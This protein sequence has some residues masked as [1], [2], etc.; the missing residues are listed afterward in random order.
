M[1][2]QMLRHV[3]GLR[4]GPVFRDGRRERVPTIPAHRRSRGPIEESRGVVRLAPNKR[5]E[6]DKREKG[7]QQDGGFWHKV[8]G[9]WR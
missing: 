1:G 6:R 2:G 8:T 4:L 5:V 3:I 9:Y 7:N